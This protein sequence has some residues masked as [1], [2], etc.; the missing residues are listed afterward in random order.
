MWSRSRA[1]SAGSRSSTTRSR[2]PAAS[3]TLVPLDLKDYRRHRP[4]RRRAPRALRPARHPGRQC[5]H[6]RAALA[7]R[8]CR[9]EGLG[10]GDG[11]QRHR[12]LA[13]DPRHRPAAAALRRRPRRV[14]HLG[15]RAHGAAPIGAPTPISKAALE[16]LARTYAAE[17]ASTNVRVNLFNPG[18]MRTRMRAQAMPG[19]DP[20]TLRD[21]GAGRGEDRRAVP[22]EHAGDR[23]ALRLSAAQVSRLPSGVVKSTRAGSEPR[24]MLT[25][26]ARQLSWR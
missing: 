25:P 12:Q 23:Q 19:E 6:A 11:G 18:P 10:R 1:P 9:A 22:A 21:A 7:A 24:G 16:A 13:A 15:R 4:A 26:A 3:A 20:M 8:P 5:R 14:R 17:T 2:P